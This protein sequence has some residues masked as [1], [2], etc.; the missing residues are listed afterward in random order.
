MKFR[1]VLSCFVSVALLFS[2][3]CRFTS[4]PADTAPQ[5][6]Q[7]TFSGPE[8]LPNLVLLAAF[9]D[10]GSAE[11]PDPRIP[12]TYPLDEFSRR[13]PEFSQLANFSGERFFRLDGGDR[14]DTDLLNLG[15][16]ITALLSQDDIAGIIVLLDREGVLETAYFLNITVQSRKPIIVTETGDDEDL[17]CSARAAISGGSSGKGVLLCLTGALLSPRETEYRDLM[18]GTGEIVG[19]VDNTVDFYFE[20]TR[21][22]TADSEFDLS[23][24]SSLPAVEIF[25]P[26][27]GEDGSRMAELLDRRPDGVVIDGSSGISRETRSLILSRDIPAVVTGYPAEGTVFAGDLSAR[28]ARLLLALALTRTSDVSEIQRMFEEY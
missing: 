26:T 1:C 19:R 22:H 25:I 11:D 10:S 23:G 16:R 6:L 8:G 9:A 15:K 27:P 13:I 28:K 12:E 5:G 2:V 4:V 20:T 7:H 3:S 17:L 18:D 21:R 24:V 14:T